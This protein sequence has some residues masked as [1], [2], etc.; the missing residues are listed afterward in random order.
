MAT[1]L[2]HLFS[3]VSINSMELKNRA[4]MPP[5]GTAYGALDSTVTDRLVQY[6]AR[7]AR[8]GTGLIITEVCAVDPRAKGF[9]SEIGIWKDDF[10]AGLSKI[11]DAVHKEGGKAAIQLHHAGR[12][13]F[14]DSTGFDPEAPSA[15]PSPTLGQPCEEMSK[16]RIGEVIEAFARS[17]ARAKKAGF[18]AVEIHGA[19]GYLLCQFL[20]P[21]SNQRTDE[22]GGSSQNRARFPL[23]VIRAVRREVG[24]D[25]PVLV[26][27]STS[28]MIKGGYD[29][30][31][32]EWL[33]PQLVEAGADAIH[34]SV[35]VYS[36]P[37]NLSIAAMDTEPGFNLERV[38]AIKQL[39]K[40]P[41]IGVGRINDPRLAEEAIARG[42][43]DLIS[44]GRQHLTDPDFIEKARRGDFE[45]IR[46]CC[47]CN[48]G[49]IERM[50]YDFKSVTCVFNPD[51]GREYKNGEG[52]GKNP[53]NIMVIGAGPAGLSAALEGLERGCNVEIF[54]KGPEPGGQLLPASRPPN[55]KIMGDWIDWAMR[56]LEKKGVKTNCGHEITEDMIR[57][58]N[59][60]A[61]ILATGSSPWAP[62]I[63]G[64]D[65]QNVFDAREVL[66]GKS[67]FEGPA[68][69]LGAGHVGMETADFLAS[70][71]LGVTVLE[72]AETPPVGKHL[73]HGYWVHSRLKHAGARLLFG[74]LV[75]EIQKDAVIYRKDGKTERI[76]PA[77]A[78]ITAL[79]SRSKTALVEILEKLAIPY[80]VVGDAKSPRHLLEAIHEGAAAA[81][82]I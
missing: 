75:T 34:A 15:I 61:V 69:I 9:A 59:P 38:R 45:D 44:F 23:E 33:A 3:P 31:F 21:F 20:S 54:E 60:E 22:Y 29:L 68:V 46:W 76:E 71:G 24:P 52:K 25:Y 58:Q 11:P 30:D 7:R 40:V 10:I 35:G 4:V 8:G 26:R 5:M 50:M 18:D 80:K 12:E 73:A 48:Q 49:C 32:A 79:G 56:Q 77:P 63:P 62:S 42:D 64:L 74:A 53:K 66:M 67:H 27:I 17:A 57:A 36:T 55:K 28:E 72:M 2:R 47:A 70:E 65:G 78:V 13:T 14:K 39:V 37:G 6:L 82:E 41:V 1:E 81:R 51:C 43:A 16:E 19:H